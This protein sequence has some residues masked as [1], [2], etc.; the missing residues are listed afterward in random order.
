MPGGQKEIADYDPTSGL[1][2]HVTWEQVT[3][4]TTTLLR[5]ENFT[6]DST[7]EDANLTSIVKQAYN[8]SDWVDTNR[9][10]Y[11]YYTPDGSG[12]WQDPKCT[13]Y[14]YEPTGSNGAGLLA[15]IIGPDQYAASTTSGVPDVAYTYNSSGQVATATVD[16]AYHYTY[17]YD[18]L[19]GSPPT[20]PSYSSY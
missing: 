11:T 15:S 8:G 2:T 19:S 3:G 4:E 14:T 5:R 13:Y 10:C 12:G 1:L 17:S 6:Y 18:T 20:D 16:G 9:A 7:D